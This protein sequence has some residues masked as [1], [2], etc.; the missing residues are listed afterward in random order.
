MRA[1]KR[2]QDQQCVPLVEHH[3][4]AEPAA[5]HVLV[6][7]LFTVG[8]LVMMFGGAKAAAYVHFVDS[9]Q[10]AKPAAVHLLVR[11]LCTAGHLV[12]MSVVE[13]SMRATLRWASISVAD[14]RK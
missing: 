5:V 10:H 7:R 1:H 6:K 13:T 12:I 14:L 4:H 3:G 9:P 11:L 8:H 2:G